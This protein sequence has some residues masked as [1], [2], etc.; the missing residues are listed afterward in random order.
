MKF[1]SKSVRNIINKAF[2]KEPVERTS[3]NRFKDALQLFLDH[4][5][6]ARN[7]NEHEE[8]FK[9][10]IIPFFNEIGFRD[11][12]INTS[13]RIDLAV[14]NACKSASGRTERCR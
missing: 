6:T 8:H 11:Y 4:I 1:D 2:L 3:F 5:E 7:K 14:H 9:N 13:A 10:F 12:F